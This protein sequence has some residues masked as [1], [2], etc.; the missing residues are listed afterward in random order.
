MTCNGSDSSYVLMWY[1]VLEAIFVTQTCILS[2]TLVTLQWW[3]QKWLFCEHELVFWAAR[4][5]IFANTGWCITFLT[6]KMIIFCASFFLRNN[7]W[8][9]SV[10]NMILE[11]G[12]MDSN[13]CHVS[14]K[15]LLID[16][17][18]GLRNKR[19]LLLLVHYQLF[20]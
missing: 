1:K 9:I 12:S 8:L 7:T 15:I 20:C 3:L 19:K 16:W 14:R 13:W 6:Y 11:I 5:L 2:R 17:L 18:Y 4:T 10:L